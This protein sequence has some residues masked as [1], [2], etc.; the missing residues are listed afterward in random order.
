MSRGP[1]ADACRATVYQEERFRFTARAVRMF[2]PG[3]AFVKL[4]AWE[5]AGR[6][7][8]YFRPDGQ[9]NALRRDQRD[10]SA[11]LSA[12]AWIDWL[13]SRGDERSTFPVHWDGEQEA[14]YIEVRR[15]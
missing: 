5:D 7:R 10:G 8:L 2:W 6:G 11:M 14:A 13:R 12:K 1:T 15:P 3:E 9:G 4:R